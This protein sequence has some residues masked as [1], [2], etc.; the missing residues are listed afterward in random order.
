MTNLITGTSTDIKWPQTAQVGA[1]SPLL[2]IQVEAEISP[3]S[4]Q[5]SANLQLLSKAAVQGGPLGSPTC[6]TCPDAG[7]LT[8]PKPRAGRLSKLC[9]RPEIKEN[10]PRTWRSLRTTSS[11]STVRQQVTIRAR[12][13][14][15]SSGKC[16]RYLET[17]GAGEVFRSLVLELLEVTA[18]GKRLALAS[19]TDRMQPP[20]E[21]HLAHYFNKGP[22]K[23]LLC[24]RQ[25]RKSSL[26]LFCLRQKQ[27]LFSKLLLTALSH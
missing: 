12:Q 9:Y 14:H 7:S 19:G 17:K 21:Q 11:L 26:V 5:Q 8:F 16:S 22:L 10:L 4:S 3:A 15:R 1:V 18:L 24:E 6:P 13:S 23:Y 27:P 20:Q 25:L 2:S